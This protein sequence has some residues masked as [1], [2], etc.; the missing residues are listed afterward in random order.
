MITQHRS[1][2]TTSKR[3][4]ILSLLP[5][6]LTGLSLGIL[7]VATLS[8][9]LVLEEVVVTAQKRT[10][11]LQDVPISVSTFTG[12]KME[13]AGI[14]NM[15]EMSAYIPNFQQSVSPIGS[16]VVIRGISSGLNYGFEQ[17]VVPY[18]DDISLGRSVLSR[19]PFMDLERVEVLRGP[20]NVLFGKNSIGGALSMITAK[21]TEE[22]EGSFQ[23]EYEPEYN[24]Q[25]Q[26]L[27]LSGPLTD[28]LRGRLA[29]RHATDDGYFKNDSNGNDEAETKELGVR[30]TVAWDVTENFEAT[31]KVERDKYDF[32]GRPEEI[33]FA[34]GAGTTPATNPFGVPVGS[35]YPQIAQLIG[36]TVG[37]DVGADETSQNYRRNSNFNSFN[38]VEVD[39]ATLTTNWDMESGIQMTTVSGWIEYDDNFHYDG[40][41]SGIDVFTYGVPQGYEQFSQ[42]IRFTSPSDQ[43]IEWIGGAFYQSSEQQGTGNFYVDDENLITALGALGTLIADPN[44]AALS[45]VADLQ[46]IQQYDAESDLWAVFGQ[47][48]W[49]VSD[50][51]R[52]TLGLRYTE[53]EKEAERSINVFNSNGVFDPTQ[54]IFGS[55]IFGVDY[56]NL[57]ELSATTPLGAF[58][59]GYFP[60]HKLKGDRDEESFTPTVI[61]EWD[62]NE[63]IMLYLTY[64]EGF[65]AGGFDDRGIRANNFEFEDETVTSYEVGMKG[66]FWDGRAELNV[67]YFYTEYD[68]L[69]V[70]VFDGNLGFTVGNAAQSTASGLEFDGRILLSE[71]LVLS[72]SLGYL[73]FEFDSWKDATCPPVVT[74]NTG[75][76]TCDNTGKR[77]IYTPEWSY[78]ASL[79]YTTALTSG[80]DLHATVDVSFK[81]KQFVEATLN[82]DLEQD[83]YTKINARL[84]LETEQWSVALVGKNLTD[85]EVVSF[86]ADTPLSN[87]SGAP[88]YSGYMERP[89]TVALQFRHNF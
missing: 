20:Q 21:P 2:L 78:S 56:Q 82:S 86:A 17:S 87:V 29:V 69:Q 43:K 41:L 60:I 49:H 65:K 77:N 50:V 36:A 27:V 3:P 16:Y 76:T 81:D 66:A 74:L 38:E 52:L 34:Y 23:I 4:L 45:N 89:R 40:D 75:A 14:N 19:I 46:S 85:E 11:S 80:L 71:N 72:G 35:T 67:A 64:S 10:E 63:D 30:A 31:L 22:F 84:A 61:A 26:V 58:P 7:P 55:L 73:D 70:S 47:A 44:L 42:E 62:V 25:E 18:M 79:D 24:Q 8:A 13:D 51:F 57:G 33:L 88:S 59:Q 37:Q 12:E 54:A 9:D 53:E 1:S 5:T 15:N 39:H 6:A 83:S 48:T 32:N 68:D 28:S